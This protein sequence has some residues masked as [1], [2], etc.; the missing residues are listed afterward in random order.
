MVQLSLRVL[1]QK[2]KQS[3]YLTCGFYIFNNF[4][5]T[6][7]RWLGNIT[8][9]SGTTHHSLSL[10]ESLDYV[11]TVFNDYKKIA[12]IKKFHGTVAEIGPGDNVGVALCFLADGCTRVDLA[13]RF[14]SKRNSSKQAA[15]YKALASS[16]PG[17]GKTI[18][19]CNLE[20]DSSFPGLQRYYGP[21]A[22]A[23]QFF[24]QPNVYDFIVSRSVFEH[25]DDPIRA[26]RSMVRALKPGGMLIHKVDL[27]DH[28]MLSSYFHELK[29][30]EIPDVFYRLMT[31]RS[32]YPN[33]ILINQYR[34]YVEALK[35]D[36]TFFVTQLAGAGPVIPHVPFEKIPASFLKKALNYLAVHKHKFSKS[37]RQLKDQDLIVSGFFLVLK[38]K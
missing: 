1:K 20:D 3:Y 37:L 33:R 11:Q 28:G 2:A 18:K 7:K 5:F 15:I 30:L 12:G 8:T 27:R 38:K 17:V 13:D 25:L 31:W 32:G 21:K 26:L 4:K 22:A 16:W 35:E 34:D 29:F 10:Q 6:L 24:S 9:D 36:H 14:Y 23:E 19:G